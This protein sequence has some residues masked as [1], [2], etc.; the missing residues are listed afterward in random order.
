MPDSTAN[1]DAQQ[2]TGPPRWSWFRVPAEAQRAANA[3]PGATGKVFG[4][5]CYFADAAGLCFPSHRAISEFAGTAR[6]KVIDAISRLEAAG[7]VEVIRAR[8]PD[9]RCEVNRYRVP[10]VAVLP[11]PDGIVPKRDYSPQANS[12]KTGQGSPETGLGGSPETGQG[13]KPYLERDHGTRT[14]KLRFDAA[15]LAVAG[16]MFA[17]IRALDPSAKEPNLQAWANEIRLMRERDGR[18]HEEIRALFTWA[19]ADSFWQS[20]ILSPAKLRKHWQQLSIQREGRRNGKPQQSNLFS[21][22]RHSSERNR[23]EF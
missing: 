18:T 4:A 20:N 1:A 17:A 12:P 3:L 5:L 8:K 2:G 6:S 9:G 16:E 15:D 7:L 11:P 13:T 10:T 23:A 22:A 14:S 21:A 19:N